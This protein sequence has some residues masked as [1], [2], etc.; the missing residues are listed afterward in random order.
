MVVGKTC[1]KDLPIK[2][3]GEA[4]EKVNE[5]KYLGVILN[6]FLSMRPHVESRNTK[7][8]N[9]AYSLYNLGLMNTN[10]N[11]ETKRKIYLT[12]CRPSLLYGC[13][14]IDI[15]EKVVKQMRTDECITMKRILVVDKRSSNKLMYNI[16]KCLDPLYEIYLRKLSLIQRLHENQLTKDL[17][18]NLTVLNKE[19]EICNSIIN[20]AALIA[21]LFGT[22]IDNR[23]AGTLI[24]SKI[25]ILEKET[26]NNGMIDSINYCINNRNKL[27]SLH[28][29]LKLLC[30]QNWKRK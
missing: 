8:N 16:F 4:I 11:I 18:I 3:G 15:D 14:F 5:M 22:S 1:T 26:V 20:D 30:T 17:I 9:A 13:E 27:T 12:Y 25:I 28:R 29:M 6:E 2:I 24:R 10:M 19:E 23:T 21:G 7:S